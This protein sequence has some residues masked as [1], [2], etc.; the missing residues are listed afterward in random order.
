LDTKK[1]SWTRG[2][3]NGA[4][5][6]E[7]WC[8]T[9]AMFGSKM[10]VFGGSNDRR[11]DAQVHVLDLT[12]F[13]WSR[14]AIDGPTPQARQLHT[15]VAIGQCMV[16]FGGWVPHS[17]LN[18]VH[19]LNTRTLTWS[20]IAPEWNPPCRQLH[21]AC[22]INGRM[23]VFGGYSK[24]KRMNDFYS[25][26]LEHTIS[27]LQDLCIET[28]VTH[29]PHTLPH[30]HLFSEELLLC[31]FRKMGQAGQ[32][33]QNNL[34]LFLN[35]ATLLTELSLVTC[36]DMVD[37]AWLDS[38]VSFGQPHA[39]HLLKLDLSNCRKISDQGL[40]KLTRFTSLRVVLVDGD[41]EVTNEGV[42]WI[43]QKLP[44]VSIVRVT[45]S[46]GELM[47]NEFVK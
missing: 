31:M 29:L 6:S 26:A 32:L 44:E 11:R 9:A 19:V 17:E 34:G 16:I 35:H 47:Y 15:S 28:L 13:E 7:R 27:S 42:Q 36:S 21:A 33:S 12:T 23:I 3:T 38:I 5:P 10:F 4:V 8:H 41:S 45:S 2:E 20:K 24:N 25:F 37:D 43:K 22:A 30:L 39:G 1:M 14:P 40:R 18:D 46:G